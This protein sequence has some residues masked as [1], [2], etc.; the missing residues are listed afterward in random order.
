MKN[1]GI[2]NRP[3]DKAGS[4]ELRNVR[5][6]DGFWKKYT[7]LVLDTVIPY[8]WEALNDRVPDAEP[9]YAVRNFRIA[10][11]E[12]EGSFGGLVFQDSDVAKWLEAVGY[13]LA[14]RPDP[15]L[16]K[17]ADG[18]IDIIG[19]AQQPDGYLNTYFTVKEPGKRWTNL[20]ECH[21]LYCAGHMMEAAVAYYEG[22]GK[23][24]LLDI[25][26]R[27]ADHIDSVFGSE[28]GKLRGYDGHE[29][30]ELALY[31]LYKATGNEK[32]LRLAC[33]FIN[34][35]GQKPSFF[36]REWEKR[37]GMSHWQK[38]ITPEPDL[39]YNQAHEPVRSQKDAVGHAVRA[40]YLYSAMADI[41]AETGDDNLKEAC[42]AL[43]ES[44]TKKQMYITGGIGSTHQG[45]AFSFDYD[46]PNDTAY[47]ETCASIGLVFFAQR[48]LK[49]TPLG[50]YA[51]VM[52]R[53][54]YN[55]VLSGMGREGRSFF[56]VNPLE[57]LPEACCKDPGKRHVKPVRQKWYGCACCPP[58]LS[59]LIVSLGSYIYASSS[60]TL[61]VNLFIGSKAKIAICGGEAEIIQETSYPWEGKITITLG[62]VPD[63]EFTL[64]L[65][66]PGWCCGASLQVN[67]RLA[68]IDTAAGYG[69]AAVKRYW[70]AGDKVVLDLPLEPVLIQSNPNVRENAGRVA[71]QRGPLVYCLEEADN[72]KD[73]AGIE[74][75]PDKKPQYCFDPD[76]S[77]GAVVVTGSAFRTGHSGWD[78]TLYR[79]LAREKEQEFRFRAIPYHLWA[80]RGPGEM[81]VWCRLKK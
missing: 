57:V 45:E 21:E 24:K 72:G 78:N 60:D 19:K 41:A 25:M 20:L 29:E 43:W 44:I 70:K 48:M 4:P 62:K 6:T 68:S 37:G 74:I 81:Q 1:S 77:D 69:Y 58:N 54:L 63:S 64:A 18:M 31:K 56:Y 79:P 11:G 22:T 14:V 76:F 39:S 28:P 55:S 52:E 34:E 5:I 30:V 38:C 33:Y 73:L 71:I 13:S 36:I 3:A 61:Y 26:C 8:Q 59:R 75:N 15:E 16:E 50:E 42:R 66:I 40:V 7:D 10:A 65:R 9:S 46:L 17:A 35:R 53:A 32:Y 51:D 67:G 80:N 27:Y 2:E 49:M 47:Q 23:S 12:A